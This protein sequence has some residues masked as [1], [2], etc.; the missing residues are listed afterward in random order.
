M[1]G[2][3]CNLHLAVHIPPL[4]L[5]IGLWTDVCKALLV[6]L[7]TSMNGLV[8]LL[9]YTRKHVFRGSFDNFLLLY[10]VRIILENQRWILPATVTCTCTWYWHWVDLYVNLVVQD[11]LL[12]RGILCEWISRRW[13]HEISGI[14]IIQ[15]GDT[16]ILLW[17]LI[18]IWEGEK[19][20]PCINYS[21]S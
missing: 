21:R 14:L 3:V 15:P 1:P 10:K 17:L 4:R 11:Y 6:T 19:N 16:G 12:E 18:E 20:L 7:I 13:L 9:H 8:L 2:V 5:Q